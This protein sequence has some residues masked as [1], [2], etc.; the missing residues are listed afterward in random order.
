MITKSAITLIDEGMRYR[1]SHEN[2]ESKKL[3]R[4]ARVR[5]KAVTQLRRVTIKSIFDI[6]ESDKPKYLKRKLLL[7]TLKDTYI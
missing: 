2:L 6:M 1:L 7:K 5:K 3:A 4:F